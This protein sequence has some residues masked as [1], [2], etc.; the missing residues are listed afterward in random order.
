MGLEKLNKISIENL[1]AEILEKQ[2]M[3]H[4]VNSFL[5]VEENVSVEP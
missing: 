5:A 4:S 3:S 1:S 2:R